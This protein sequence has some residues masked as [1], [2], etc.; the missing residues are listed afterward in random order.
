MTNLNQLKPATLLQNIPNQHMLFYSTGKYLCH[1]ELCY[2][3]EE[4]LLKAHF[5]EPMD[6]II[7]VTMV[8]LFY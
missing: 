2:H 4:K 3:G 1:I 6:N 5:S 8:L 7:P